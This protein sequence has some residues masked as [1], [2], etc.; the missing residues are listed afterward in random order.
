[1]LAFGFLFGALAGG[2]L[3]LFGVPRSGRETRQQIRQ[4]VSGTGDALREGLD[5]IVPGDSVAESIAEGKAAAARR[6]SELGLERLG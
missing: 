5:S 2:V 6:R 4:S 1:M 3:A